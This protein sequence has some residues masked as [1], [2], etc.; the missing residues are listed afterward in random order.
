VR[1]LDLHRFHGDENYWLCSSKNF[2]LF[3]I[4]RDFN[5]EEWSTCKIEPVGKYIIGLALSIA[6]YGERIEEL[7]KMKPWDHLKDYTWN[8]AHRR[9]PPSELLSVARFTMA[10]LGSL[11]CMMIYWI[12]RTIFSMKAGIVASLLLAYNPLMLL[13]CRRAMTDAPLLFFLTTNTILVIYFYRSL[14][15]QRLLRTLIVTTLIGTN[16]ALATGTK[17]NGGLAGI[18]F[19]LFC[20]YLVL[21]KSGFYTFS[22][23]NFYTRIIQLSN[24]REIKLI[25]TSLLISGITTIAVFIS[26]N[27][28]L[29]RQP[30]DGTLQ[31]IDYRT[32]HIRYQQT[33]WETTLDSL[34]KKKFNFVTIRTLFPKNYVILGTI[35]KVPIDC[36]LFLI[37][38]VILL[39]TEVKYIYNNSKP[40][41]KSIIILWTAV[42]F[43]GITIWIPLDWE[44]YYLPIIPCIVIIEGYC[45]AK[46]FDTFVLLIRQRI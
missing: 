34:A 45:I 3:F 8:V 10:L 25:L 26:M 5:N 24:D 22:K 12:G 44:R 14:V 36:G 2:K 27:P 30:V 20:I 43:T 17:L 4:D 11:T 46:I 42:T 1:K 9:M 35:F 19:T 40:S 21:I 31:M 39:Y 29:Y 23:K 15:K 37:G 33:H 38:L 41:L 6:G 28:C 16:C 32:A 18:I 7:S 13:C